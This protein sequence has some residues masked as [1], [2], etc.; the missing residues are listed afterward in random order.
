ML[1]QDRMDLLD[2]PLEEQLAPDGQSPIVTVIR[3]KIAFRVRSVALE[4]FHREIYDARPTST[5]SVHDYNRNATRYET[6][7]SD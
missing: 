2:G 4:N 1:A 3:W 6:I 7:I 5:K